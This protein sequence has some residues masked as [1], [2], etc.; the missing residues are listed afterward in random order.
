M[1]SIKN[2]IDIVRSIGS[3]HQWEGDDFV[4]TLKSQWLVEYEDTK[5][6]RIAELGSE[7]LVDSDETMHRGI[8]LKTLIWRHNSERIP[9]SEEE[10]KLVAE[11]LKQALVHLEPSAELIWE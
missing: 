2:I 10:T 11:R 7:P 6:H 3:K 4:V 9:A 1:I 5:D 8:Y